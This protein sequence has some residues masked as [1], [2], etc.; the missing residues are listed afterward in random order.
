LRIFSISFV[1]N[2]AFFNGK[3]GQKAQE[4]K[5]KE[6]AIEGLEQQG[7]NPKVAIEFTL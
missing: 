4:H 3:I 5:A 7:R 2:F 6:L 1:R